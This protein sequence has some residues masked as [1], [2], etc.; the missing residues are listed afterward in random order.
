MPG[1]RDAT[2]AEKAALYGAWAS[3]LIVYPPHIQ[4][5]SQIIPALTLMQSESCWQDLSYVDRSK[6]MQAPPSA[7]V[8]G[9][10]ESPDASPT[11]ESAAPA[12]FTVGVVEL[13][14]AAK[15]DA[16]RIDPIRRR[17]LMLPAGARSKP[18]EPQR[19]FCESLDQCVPNCVDVGHSSQR[20]GFALKPFEEDACFTPGIAPEPSRFTRRASSSTVTGDTDP[21]SQSGTDSRVPRGEAV[22]DGGVD[23]NAVR[24]RHP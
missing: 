7:P 23:A 19:Y 15:I 1:G 4:P 17:R 22:A 18:S 16:I 10:A 2:A 3:A 6:S 14:A 21:S 20:Y 8:S 9:A 5:L 11:A 13:H 24:R 12:S